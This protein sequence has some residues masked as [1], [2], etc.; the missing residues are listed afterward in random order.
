MGRGGGE[1]GYDDG[2]RT[3]IYNRQYRVCFT[4]YASYANHR[5]THSRR[6]KVGGTHKIIGRLKKKQS[7]LSRI[8][9]GELPQCRVTE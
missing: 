2:T 3:L 5:H 9:C 4:A 6:G 8:V 7:F 1:G